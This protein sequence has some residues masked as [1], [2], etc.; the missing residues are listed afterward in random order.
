MTDQEIL[1][2]A[3][4]KAVKNG[5][6]FSLASAE[7]YNKYS[8]WTNDSEEHD[9]YKIIFSHDFAKAFWGTEKANKFGL[10][11]YLEEW[12]VRLADI[13]LSEN[14]INYLEKFL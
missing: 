13:V 7:K 8:A 4:E 1:K 6:D 12:Q 11:P 10:N 14:P 5:Y 3:I 9:Y 2:K